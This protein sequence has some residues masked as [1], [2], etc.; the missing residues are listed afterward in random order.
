MWT[1]LALCP[2]AVDW[3]VVPNESD[4]VVYEI[5]ANGEHPRRQV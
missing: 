2:T 3:N 5:E 1:F 4:E